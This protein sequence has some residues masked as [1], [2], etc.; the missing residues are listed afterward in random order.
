M[1]A[2][3]KSQGYPGFH[4]VSGSIHSGDA[5]TPASG[6][7]IFMW[8][9]SKQLYGDIDDPAAGSL[10]FPYNCLEPDH[11]NIPDPLAGVLASPL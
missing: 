4:A 9:G 8:S 1:G 2:S 11:M 10:T 3:L 6:S 5:S 7:G